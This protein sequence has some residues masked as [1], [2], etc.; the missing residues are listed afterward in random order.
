MYNTYSLGTAGAHM[1]TQTSSIF[2][3]ISG[4]VFSVLL[5]S[6]TTFV[7]VEHLWVQ[8]LF[9]DLSTYKYL[10]LNSIPPSPICKCQ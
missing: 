2:L 1:I 3:E 9:R 5:G 6:S 8:Y 10:R 7:K 4:P